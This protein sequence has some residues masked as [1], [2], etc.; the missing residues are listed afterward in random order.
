M[1]ELFDT[2]AKARQA[3]NMTPR[4]QKHRIQAARFAPSFAPSRTGT[5]ALGLGFGEWNRSLPL[6]TP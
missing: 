1:I 5:S 6:D 2:T 3:I 4:A